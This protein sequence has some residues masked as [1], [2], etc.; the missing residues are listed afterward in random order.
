MQKIVTS[1]GIKSLLIDVSE[2]IE[3]K[4]LKKFIFIMKFKISLR[5]EIPRCN[6]LIT[7]EKMQSLPL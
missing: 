3:N 6:F 2:E 4:N 7:Y 5:L 1:N